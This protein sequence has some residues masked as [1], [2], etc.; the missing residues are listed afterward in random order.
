LPVSAIGIHK[1][2]RNFADSRTAVFANFT[3]HICRAGLTCFPCINIAIATEAVIVI[4]YVTVC[5]AIVVIVSAGG[6]LSV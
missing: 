3:D 1:T 4:A 2:K 6:N 5:R